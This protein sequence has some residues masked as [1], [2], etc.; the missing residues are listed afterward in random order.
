MSF[1]APTIETERLRLRHHRHEDFAP[2]AALFSTDWAR[3]MGG[4]ISNTDLWR[5]LGAEITSWQWLGL[6]S[7]AVDLKETGEL[8]GQV[9]INKPPNYPE[10][11]LGWC[12]FPTYEGK[13]YAFEMVV[14]ARD[15]GFTSAGLQT[16]VSYID[17]LNTRSITLAKR[18]GAVQDKTA[19][20]PDP[21]DLVFRHS[22]AVTVDE[23][24]AYA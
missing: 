3:Y 1:A 21:E 4:P 17:P 24:E 14:A 12:V 9:G 23:L 16:L 19:A 10:V 20:V 13:S 11:E 8:I 7:W 6:G 15:W 2:M 5:W 22:A 18:L